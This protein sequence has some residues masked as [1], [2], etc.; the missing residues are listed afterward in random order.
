M[1]VKCELTRADGVASDV[2][3]HIVCS[4]G[5]AQANH[6]CLGGA[7]STAYGNS[8]QTRA[9]RGH[10][11]DAARY[12]L[13]PPLGSK[14]EVSEGIHRQLQQQLYIMQSGVSVT[15]ATQLLLV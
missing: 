15:M 1:V 3:R 11:D 7:I 5:F 2:L 10:V 13:L 4:N 14:A 9:D 12:A 8:L 6:S